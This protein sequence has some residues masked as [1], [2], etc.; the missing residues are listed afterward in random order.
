MG[1]I[2]L[3]EH[4]SAFEPEPHLIKPYTELFERLDAIMDQ[5]EQE[6]KATWTVT[7]CQQMIRDLKDAV[8]R[9]N[10][11][12]RH[13][14]WQMQLADCGLQPLWDLLHP[15]DDRDEIHLLHAVIRAR[16]HIGFW[17]CMLECQAL[18]IGLTRLAPALGEGPTSG[19]PLGNRA[20]VH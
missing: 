18:A 6:G 1:L 8:Y 15:A 7:R 9:A 17:K 19:Q 11:P 16:G 10:L 14:I 4:Q 5:A 20:V 2:H 12:E 13:T 3:L